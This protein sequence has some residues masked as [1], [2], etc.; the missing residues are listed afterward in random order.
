[1][2]NI[3]LVN[4]TGSILNS[5]GVPSCDRIEFIPISTPTQFPNVLV[6][7][8]KIN[9]SPDNTGAFS[10]NL[11]NGYYSCSFYDS[12]NENYKTDTVVI[13]V[14]ASGS[15]TF[16]SL[17]SSSL[18]SLPDI[19]SLSASYALTSSY[20]VSSSYAPTPNLSVINA[21]VTINSMQNIIGDSAELWN[22]E[23]TSSLL[24]LNGSE[25]NIASITYPLNTSNGSSYNCA[26]YVTLNTMDVG[27]RFR[28]YGLLDGGGEVQMHE[29]TGT[30]SVSPIYITD[31]SGLGNWS[32]IR[33]EIYQQYNG[34]AT[35]IVVGQSGTSVVCIN[36]S[37]PTLTPTIEVTDYSAVDIL[38]GH[39]GVYTIG[40]THVVTIVNGII[41]NVVVLN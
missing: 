15:V 17:I 3:N 38:N 11:C 35:S 20:A 34:A 12:V 36:N 33:F 30:I 2:A 6:S 27:C 39:T 10:V 31:E 24:E 32:G 28:I 1:M 13:A 22:P 41:T 40:G 7:T 21:P 37:N 8:H 29:E 14:P 26:F 18:I 4:I 5:E 23:L 9:V 19:Q 25:D 16:N